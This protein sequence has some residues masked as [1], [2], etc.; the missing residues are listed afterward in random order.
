[1]RQGNDPTR[2]IS[3]P[4]AYDEELRDVLAERISYVGSAIHKTKPGDYGFNPPVNPRPWKSICDGMR[5]ILLAEAR[6]MFASGI[7]KG[8]FSKLLGDG[9]PKYVWAVDHLGEAYEA[10]ISPNT[11]TYKG[12]RLEEDDSMRAVV[13]REWSK[14]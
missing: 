11:L 4:D 5:V 12:Y 13:L 9:I 2:R 6:A 1:M 7:R 14:R 8:M 10:K 3:P